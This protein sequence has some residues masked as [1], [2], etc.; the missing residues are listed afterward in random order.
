MLGT[1]WSLQCVPQPDD[2]QAFTPTP[3]TAITLTACSLGPAEGLCP[4]FHMHGGCAT[5]ASGTL[6]GSSPLTFRLQSSS[7]GG[8]CPEARAGSRSRHAEASTPRSM[9]TFWS[10]HPLAWRLGILLGHWCFCTDGGLLEFLLALTSHLVPGLG[11]GQR[12]GGR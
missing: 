5:H 8:A 7:L 9:S 6:L 10:R 2:A 4:R 1:E 3:H 11:P 12:D